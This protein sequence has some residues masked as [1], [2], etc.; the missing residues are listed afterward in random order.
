[1]NLYEKLVKQC[2]LK[3]QVCTKSDSVAGLLF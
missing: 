3:V 2:T 1:M